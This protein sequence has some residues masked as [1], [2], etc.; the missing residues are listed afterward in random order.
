MVHTIACS[1]DQYCFVNILSIMIELINKN[2]LDNTLGEIM[3]TM[4][5]AAIW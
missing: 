2:T 1:Y 3:P 4:A 5:V